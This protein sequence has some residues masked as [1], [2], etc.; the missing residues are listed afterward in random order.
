MKHLSFLVV[1][2]VCLPTALMAQHGLMAQNGLDPSVNEIE[3]CLECHDLAAELAAPIAHPPAQEGDCSACHN[4]HASRFSALLRERPGPLCLSCH[5]DMVAEIDQASVHLPVT[6]G[7]CADCHPP[8][9]AEHKKLLHAEKNEVCLSCHIEVE[10]W[11][12]MEV[13]HNPFE[14]GKCSICHDP[15]AAPFPALA[16]RDVQRMCVMCHRNEEKMGPA[17]QG[18]PVA[19][20]GDCL[21]CHDP[22]ASGRAGLFPPQ[23]HLPFKEGACDDCH[24]PA[25]AQEPFALVVEVRELCSDCHE[26]VVA[27]VQNAPFAHLGAGDCSECHNS[28]MGDEHLLAA[29]I[30]TVCLKC[31]DPG[32]ASSGEP[33]RY[34]SHGGMEC[35]DCHGAH[36]AGRPSLLVEDP[37]KSCGD[38]HSQEHSI[39]HPMG[40]DSRDPRNGQPMDC[41]SCHG[42]HDAPYEDYMHKAGDRELCLSCHKEMERGS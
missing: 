15:H 28:H 9:G 35:T 36:G 27:E 18:Y 40:E 5:E 32:G 30:E 29:D 39:A 31:H 3:V 8:H 22:H 41:L 12:Q 10:E 24:A 25:D 38:C 6:E 33:G 13:L 23:L 11:Q 2:A 37:L 19:E 42:I 4:P 16:H 26:G 21:S 20:R 7:R 34:L 17:H 1:L 14:R